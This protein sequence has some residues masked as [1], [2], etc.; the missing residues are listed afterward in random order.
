MTQILVDAHLDIA[1]NVLALGRDFSL[2]VAEIRRHEEALPKGKHRETCMVSLPAMLEGHIAVAGGSIFVSP[3]RKSQELNPSAY[4]EVHARAVA[5]LDYYRRLADEDERVT[6]LQTVAD[7][8]GVLQTWE[9]GGQCLGLFI[10]MEGADPI[11][12]AGELT[13]W[14][15]RGLR[16]VGLAWMAGS[17]YA[18]G[19]ANPGPITDEGHDFLNAMADY[20]LLLDLSHLWIDDIYEA[21]DRYPGPIV[22]TH[23][24]PAAFVDTPRSFADDVIRRIAD[25]GGVIG[26]MPVNTMLD[27]HWRP[28]DPRLPLERFVQAIDHVCQVAGDAAYVGIGSDLDGGFGRESV[29]EDLER[30]ADLETI[31]PLLLER[32]YTEADVTAI[33][34]GN[35]LRV[36][37]E[38]LAGF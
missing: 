13:W 24:T 14:V 15:E 4:Q 17:R 28:G 33:L 9:A 6:L 32:N 30:I 22:G 35:W 2:P 23:T 37:R 18:G 31:R 8:E 5:Q 27:P 26:M 21:L 34:S 36:I 38:V 7:L 10:V 1:H 3:P 11:R 25:R 20:N 16:G 29:P 12:E 19:N